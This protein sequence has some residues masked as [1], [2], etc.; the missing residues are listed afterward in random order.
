VRRH[1]EWG[2]AA[3]PG[4]A[5]TAR[6]RGVPP[7]R[8][9]RSRA[10]G[11]DLAG[12]G[13]TTGHGRRAVPSRPGDARYGWRVIREPLSLP[14][15]TVIF[16]YGEVISLSQSPE[17]RA[18]LERLAGV[19]GADGADGADGGADSARF[20]TSYN[21]HRDGLDQGTGGVAAYWAAVAGDIG[22]SWDEGRVH[23]LWAAD[24]RSWLSVNP[25]V[26]DLLTDLR[27]G[28]TPLA[29]LSNAGPDYG[30]Y[31][32]HGPLGDLF[33]ACYVSGE[34][35]LLKPDPEIFLH[36][37]GDL[38]IRAAEAV[39]I[40]NKASNVAGAQALGI[41]G[42]V[43]TG[44]CALRAFLARLAAQASDLQAANRHAEPGPGPGTGNGEAGLPRQRLSTWCCLRAGRY[45]TCETSA[46]PRRPAHDP[47]GV[48]GAIG[49][50][51]IPQAVVLLSRRSTTS[52][53]MHAVRAALAARRVAGPEPRRSRSPAEGSRLV[54]RP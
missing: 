37:L 14:G 36:V 39:F 54:P 17:D 30:S 34:L 52:K 5:R 12:R 11:R 43:F 15:R 3:V 24:F 31:F 9:A 19:G 4:G 21:A 42:H 47:E 29:L 18:A 20:W 27:A 28:G 22:A 1:G 53:G 33:A 16:D 46:L 49:D 41:T 44:A 6:E 40:D 25:D 45:R 35:R 26:I 8:G 2:R 23:E 7:H 51:S 32:R 13:R 38:G 10:R 50:T 48:C